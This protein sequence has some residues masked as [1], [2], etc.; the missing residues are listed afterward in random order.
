MTKKFLFNV[1]VICFIGSLL[2]SS[3]GTAHEVGVK[4]GRAFQIHKIIETL[5]D[6][7]EARV[8]LNTS[9]N[10]NDYG[11]RPNTTGDCDGYIGG[12]SGFDVTH[13]RDTDAPFY[14]LSPGT[15]IYVRQP[16]PGDMSELSYIAIYNE[17]DKK[18]ILYLHPSNIEVGVD[19]DVEVGTLLGNQGNTGNS[20]GPHVHIEVRDGR[21]IYPSCGITHSSI[22][23]HP[24]EDP[25][26]Y[27]YESLN[28]EPDPLPDSVVSIEPDSIASPPVG[29]ELEF[30]LEIEDGVDVFG[31]QATIVFDKTALRHLTSKTGGY[32]SGNPFFDSEVEGNTIT[33]I[34]TA[35]VGQSRGDGTLATLV[36]E[37]IAVK[38]STLEITDVRLSN[39]KGQGFTPRVK[40][41]EIT[42]PMG[43]RE[44]VNRDGT[45]NI[46]DLV[47]VA[48]NIGK[49]VKNNTD[50][51][52]DGIVNIQDLVLVAVSIGSDG[53]GP[54]SYAN[55]H[56]MLTAAD[57]QH[58]LS[59]ARKLVLTDAK[60]QRGIRVLEQLHATL[61][62]KQTLLL[63]NYP[64]PF[65]PETWI[66]YH[67]AKPADVT[68]NIYAANG[69]I[70]RTIA[71]GVMPAGIYQ[72][73]SRAAYWDGKN[74]FGEPVT[75][76]VYFY[77]LI[78]G[79]FTATRKM[80]ILK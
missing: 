49:P 54:S 52:N 25:I 8:H 39:I 5:F 76:G 13:T 77:T 38:E 46:L 63:P 61:V 45:V 10:Y 20:T 1:L 12:H 19:E 34:S 23:G 14:S 28:G 32:L 22:S 58:W 36:F 30:S 24:N 11:N 60:L 26:P 2:I 55:L 47:L 33:L 21:T 75:S 31:Y 79:K 16:V 7:S 57:V 67:L 53:A 66:P 70:V 4:N 73:R 17:T 71:L 6:L 80:L 29:Q 64:N 69:M 68:L 65:N 43:P 3:I 18:T 50:I 59:Q 72:N 48:S 56:Q 51:N 15:V 62:P 74:T 40:H 41:A 37:V 35:Y 27:L 42:K 78:A 44:D 9:H